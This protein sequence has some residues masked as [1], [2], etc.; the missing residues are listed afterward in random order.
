MVV[1]TV[2]TPRYNPT[3][4]AGVKYPSNLFNCIISGKQFQ[5]AVN[6]PFRVNHIV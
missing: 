5:T 4:P 1:T 6:I 3:I 2:G